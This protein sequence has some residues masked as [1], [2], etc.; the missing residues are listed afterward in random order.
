MTVQVALPIPLLLNPRTQSNTLNTHT[1]EH[2]SSRQASS[3]CKHEPLPIQAAPHKQGGGGGGGG[4]LYLR[5]E[6]E[7]PGSGR[8]AERTDELRGV[9]VEVGGK[10]RTLVTLRGGVRW[11]PER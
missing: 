8:R 1:Q 2:N 3:W 7:K 5:S 6:I 10:T 9:R 4:L 11:C